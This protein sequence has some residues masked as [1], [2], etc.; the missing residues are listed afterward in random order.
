MLD[1]KALFRTKRAGEGSG[2]GQVAL[3][4]APFV[5]EVMQRRLAAFALGEHDQPPGRQVKAVDRRRPVGDAPARQISLH[6]VQQV[7]NVALGGG[8]GRH[9]AALE[10]DQ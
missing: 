3:A 7:G 6:A 8:L 9:P 10:D 2:G 4:D 5:E 1:S